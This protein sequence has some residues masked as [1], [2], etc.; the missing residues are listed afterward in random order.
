MPKRISLADA[1]PALN[2]PPGQP[3]DAP[4]PDLPGPRS[5]PVIPVALDSIA[6]QDHRLR[7]VD[8]EA[9]SRLAD[10]IAHI[11]LQSPILLRP[12]RGDPGA[13]VLVAGAHRLEAVRSL[14]W[15]AVDALIVDATHD[16]LDL[17]EIDENLVRAELTPLD[18]AR[19]LDRR[20]QIYMRIGGGAARGGDRKSAAWAGT[21]AAN[22]ARR[23]SWADDAAERIGL[24]KRSVQ[25][26]V[27]IGEGLSPILAEALAGT[28][29]AHRE[30]DLFRLAQMPK[31]E[32]HETLHLLQQAETPPATLA[33]LLG[34][35]SPQTNASHLEKLKRDWSAAPPAERRQF[36]AWLQDNGWLPDHADANNAGP[37]NAG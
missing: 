20:K 2:Q 36:L 23:V 33:Q 5:R 14:G 12:D 4:D 11:G 15:T 26:A 3:F 31:P 19:F 18:R 29:I 25:R 37:S 6:I 7:K 22:D 30:A 34:P 24:S 17:I 10:S 27:A 28:P 9:A 13:Y 16:E 8:T 35:A 21:A 32:Q 1:I